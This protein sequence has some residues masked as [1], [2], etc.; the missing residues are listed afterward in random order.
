[1]L[2][3]LLVDH[4]MGIWLQP[5]ECFSCYYLT[6]LCSEDRKTRRQW[7]LAG[8]TGGGTGYRTTACV[9]ANFHYAIFRGI[10]KLHLIVWDK[11]NVCLYAFRLP[12]IS[13]NSSSHFTAWYIF[14]SCCHPL[15]FVMDLIFSYFFQASRANSRDGKKIVAILRQ[16]FNKRRRY[17][18]SKRGKTRHSWVNI[19]YRLC[20]AC[21]VKL[22][23][24][25]IYEEER[26]D[27][28]PQKNQHP[29]EGSNV[30]SGRQ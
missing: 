1:L 17:R 10:C 5:V 26:R 25:D 13:F 20:A 24:L 22:L 3:V 11:K 21:L 16:V 2:S 7:I 8:D 28:I 6:C 19:F 4:F 30:I 27:L 15:T 29:K 12:T 14:S 18:E 23:K 9:S